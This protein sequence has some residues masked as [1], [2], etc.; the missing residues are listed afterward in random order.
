MNTLA[1]VSTRTHDLR[2]LLPHAAKGKQF[3]EGLPDR[4]IQLFDINLGRKAIS[5][6]FKADVLGDGIKHDTTYG[7]YS[8][9]IKP[10]DKD[11]ENLKFVGNVF[12]T[13]EYFATEEFEQWEYKSPVS[14]TS[15]FLKLP[16]NLSF[17]NNI[18]VDK[19]TGKSSLRRGDTITVT[20]TPQIWVGFEKQQYGVRFKVTEI[21]KEVPKKTKK[22]TEVE[23]GYASPA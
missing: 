11:F 23:D 16:K 18:R 17:E 12:T 3:P 15:L 20:V 13:D 5:F 2:V 9:H 6:I 22:E 10:S 21:R 1:Q 7:T 4:A 14:D 19:K 8:I